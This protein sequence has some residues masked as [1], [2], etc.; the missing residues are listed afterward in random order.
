MWAESHARGTLI[1]HGLLFVIVGVVNSKEQQK[2]LQTRAGSR[3]HQSEPNNTIQSNWYEI[4][5]G[6]SKKVDT[7]RK[8]IWLILVPDS[9]WSSHLWG[10]YW[11]AAVTKITVISS[12]SRMA[13]LNPERLWFTDEQH[14]EGKRQTCFISANV[15]DEESLMSLKHTYAHSLHAS[16][17]EHLSVSADSHTCLSALRAIIVLIRWAHIWQLP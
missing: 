10:K 14:D 11:C 12:K 9:L 4:E 1:G 15:T 7:K 17:E 16:V 13:W 3:L 5:L 8:I 2:S 6:M